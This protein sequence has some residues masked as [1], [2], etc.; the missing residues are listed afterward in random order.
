MEIISIPKIMQ[1]T[2]KEY[3][4]DGKTIGLV[5]TMGALHEGHLS[6]VGRAK[7]ENDITVVSIFVNPIQFGASEDLERYPRDIEGDTEKLRRE[8]V[9]IIFMPEISSMYPE[10]FLTY[11]EVEKIS[12]RLCGAFRPGHFRGVATVVTKLLNIVKPTRAYF[13]QKDFQQSIIIKQLVKDLNMDV[14]VVVCPT[15]RE[16]DGLAMSSRNA[17]LDRA[18]REAA[19]V[20]YRCLKEASDLIKSGVIDRTYIKGL[21]QDRLLKEPAVS[22]VDYAGVYDPETMNELSEIKGDVLL[23]VAL[24][25]GD[26]RLIDNMLVT[27]SDY[28][29]QQPNFKS[30]KERA[31]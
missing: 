1:E 8:K 14:D 11:V 25:I 10:V 28:Q 12:E 22:S 6:L 5:P 18:Q 19:T 15:V 23:T 13:G 7:Q 24:R 21:M 17:Y 31:I 9:D 16:Q 30:L 20:I 26:T 4:V 3:L 29:I 2:S 27:S